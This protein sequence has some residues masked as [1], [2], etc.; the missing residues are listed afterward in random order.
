MW[1]LNALYTSQ[2]LSRSF[3]MDIEWLLSVIFS[4]LLFL[5]HAYQLVLVHNIYYWEKKYCF[6][7]IYCFPNFR[8]SPMPKMK[9]KGN[10]RLFFVSFLALIHAT[11]RPV[12][13]SF[14]LLLTFLHVL[15]EQHFFL[16]DVSFCLLQELTVILSTLLPVI[17]MNNDSKEHSGFSVGLKVWLHTARPCFDNDVF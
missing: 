5:E 17:C 14:F 10:G 12:F 8:F 7:L 16:M 6:V 1:L 9:R 3:C 15:Y 2:F 11:T 4:V 13:L